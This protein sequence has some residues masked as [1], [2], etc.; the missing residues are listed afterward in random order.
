MNRKHGN[1]W[2]LNGKFNAGMTKE[3]GWVLHFTVIR[4]D[5]IFFEHESDSFQF[6]FI[7]LPSLV[8]IRLE[9]P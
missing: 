3:I 6:T 2:N 7:Y 5:S 4:L 1:L 8:S 9:L